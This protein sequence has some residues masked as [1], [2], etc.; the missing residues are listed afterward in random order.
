MRMN[1]MRTFYLA[2][3]PAD[4]QAPSAPSSFLFHFYRHHS[5]FPSASL[6]PTVTPPSPFLPRIQHF[7]DL[8]RN[9]AATLGRLCSLS[10][11]MRRSLSQFMMWRS[12]FNAKSANSLPSHFLRASFIKLEHGVLELF[13]TQIK[14]GLYKFE[15]KKTEKNDAPAESWMTLWPSR[16]YVPF[17]GREKCVILIATAASLHLSGRQWK[18]LWTGRK[19]TFSPSS[20]AAWCITP[21][22]SARGT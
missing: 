11:H 8:N 3:L 6:T 2:R 22:S 19:L 12:R 14:C 15:L 4:Y 5:L 18:G 13:V 7:D 9:A 16:C 1:E 21:P 20:T 10:E 17:L